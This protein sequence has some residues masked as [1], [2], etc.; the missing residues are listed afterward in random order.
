MVE[1]VSREISS[2]LIFVL[3][4][5]FNFFCKKF[6]FWFFC[7]DWG[8]FFFFDFLREINGDFFG[9]LGV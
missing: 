5:R 4:N 3:Q 7:L 9:L 6:F 1:L 8:L 2:K